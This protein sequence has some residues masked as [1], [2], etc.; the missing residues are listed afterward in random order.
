MRTTYDI[1]QLK[2][3]EENRFNRPFLHTPEKAQKMRFS[4]FKKHKAKEREI[5]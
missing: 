3:E 5:S 1:N 4:V 2:L